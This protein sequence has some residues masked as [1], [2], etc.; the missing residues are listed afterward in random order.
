MTSFRDTSPRRLV[1]IAHPTTGSPDKVLG[2]SPLVVHEPVGEKNVRSTIDITSHPHTPTHVPDHAYQVRMMKI[3]VLEGIEE[4]EG[5][6]SA[7]TDETN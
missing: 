2:D 3:R 7:K 1:S 5:D 4:E 6:R